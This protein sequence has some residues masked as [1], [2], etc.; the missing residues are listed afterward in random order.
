[1]PYDLRTAQPRS[2]VLANARLVLETETVT[3][4]LAVRDGRIAAIDTGA[5]VPAH[6]EDCGGDYLAPGL[7]ELH[8]DNLERHLEPR[9]GV[10]WPAVPAILAH[11]AEL[12]GTGITT[13][14]DALRVGSL[15][16]SAQA[17][18]RRYARPLA[19]EINRLAASG[20][21]RIRHRLHLRAET[22]SETL[23]DELAEFAP[24]D[25]VGVLS[26]MDHTPGQRQFAD[27]S[28][29]RDYAASRLDMD[30]DAFEAH[31]A[32]LRALRDRNGARHE[33]AAAAAARRLG[34]TLASHDDATPAQVAAS[35]AHGAR[36]AEFPTTFEA[37]AACRARGVAVMMGAPNLI[38]G[39]SHAGNV[40][41]AALAEAGLLDILSSDYAPASLLLG[42][43]RLGELAGGLPAALAAGIA[44]VTAAPARA[45][46]LAD[47]GRLAS[48]LRADLL[49]FRLEHG[50]PVPRGVWVAGAR[51]A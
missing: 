49:R 50:H 9:P 28:R 3:G 31:V 37:A 17:R 38:R 39:G 21:L 34:A 46:G 26:L 20:A 11:D 18:H 36:I 2:L 35:A 14:F 40:P 23:E 33:A 45:A 15:A 30:D 48:G 10:R 32:R 25:R 41:A 19:T 16:S 29:L 51:V 8:T 12:A 42:A 5:S 6:A 7:V 27:V 4:S 22:C 44:A 47:R 24:E 43:V 1:M 13:V